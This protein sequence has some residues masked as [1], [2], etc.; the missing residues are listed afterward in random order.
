MPD[1]NIYIVFNL[2]LRSNKV[3]KYLIVFVLNLL[4]DVLSLTFL[5]ITSQAD[6]HS[7]CMAKF[8]GNTVVQ[9]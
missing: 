6:F 9:R 7:T 3:Q 2:H 4:R 5:A 8:K 1:N